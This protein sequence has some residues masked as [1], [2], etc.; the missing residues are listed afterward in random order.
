MKCFTVERDHGP[1]SRNDFKTVNHISKD[2]LIEKIYLRNPVTFI[3]RH[4]S[5]ILPT[6]VLLKPN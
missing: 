3:K 1:Y 6:G 5:V 4:M 2:G